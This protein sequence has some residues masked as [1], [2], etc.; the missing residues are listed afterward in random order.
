MSYRWSSIEELRAALVGLLES[1]HSGLVTDLRLE[2][3]GDTIVLSGEVASEACRSDAKRLALAFDGIFKVRN[4]L[5]VAAF[6]EAASDGQRHRLLPD[7]SFR[8]R[9]LPRGATVPS[10]CQVSSRRTSNHSMFGEG[11]APPWAHEAA[12]GVGTGCVP[13]RRGSVIPKAGT[14]PSAGGFA[15]YSNSPLPSGAGPLAQRPSAAAVPSE[16]F[17][18]L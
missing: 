16:W 10:A 14:G 7:R 15:T 1:R 11:I 6:L 17:R 4:K 3:D 5:V 12:G 13:Y 18:N 8:P 2:A 9:R